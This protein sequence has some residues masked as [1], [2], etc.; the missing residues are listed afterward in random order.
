MI[1]TLVIFSSVITSVITENILINTELFSS[2]LPVSCTLVTSKIPT[3][4]LFKFK[5]LSIQYGSIILQLEQFLS[6]NIDNCTDYCLLKELCFSV[7]YLDG[8]CRFHGFSEIYIPIE[9]SGILY[10][11]ACCKGKNLTFY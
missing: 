6:N 8:V 5:W 10:Y 7:T 11:L 3:S 4:C 9:E 1:C 2:K